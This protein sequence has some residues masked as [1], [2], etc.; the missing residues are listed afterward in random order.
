MRAAVSRDF[1]FA[2]FED[3]S[4]GAAVRGLPRSV[5][6]DVHRVGGR[7]H[8]A[9]VLVTPD[10]R[11]E[12]LRV[13]SARGANACRAVVNR[14]LTR[15]SVVLHA[16]GLDP[17]TS[18]A[19]PAAPVEAPPPVVAP[20]P[21]V[22]VAPPLVL[23][24]SRAATEPVAVEVSAERE[25]D[26]RWTLWGQGTVGFAYETLPGVAPTLSA[27][28]HLERSAWSVGVEG[29]GDLPVAAAEIEAF[30]WGV[31]LSACRAFGILGLCALGRG[32]AVEARAPAL[33]AAQS[34]S[35]SFLEFG[36]RAQLVFPLG[37]RFAVT[38]AAE[39]VGQVLGARFVAATAMGN[40]VIWE[41]P[42]AS[43]GVTAGFRVRIW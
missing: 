19:A 6:I 42:W 28:I 2:F 5:R 31:G 38:L 26:Q 23:Q 40:D 24:P 18:P 39:G 43:L 36:V 34:G 29:R 33:R 37:S 32:G 13:R 3:G 14:L 10:G 20:S 27:A 4:E 35:A 21:M 41:V 8:G 15:F 25:R 7:L 9:V 22:A 12:V 30:R 17:P 16:R 1:G 11:E